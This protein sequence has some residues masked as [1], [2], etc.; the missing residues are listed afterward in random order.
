M[1]PARNERPAATLLQR[2]VA[3]LARREHS[4]VELALKLRR[5]V[6][7]GQDAAAD[8]ESVLDELQ[9]RGLLSETRYAEAIVR[10]RA[11]RY[12]NARLAQDL[13]S[14]GVDRETAQNA[15]AA[16]G[17]SEL[18]RAKAVWARRFDSLPKSLDE[19]ARQ[20]RYLQA[21]GFSADTI[22]AVLTGRLGAE[23]D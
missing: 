16:I 14:R 1:T 12:G 13:Q 22:R 6:P 4:R 15:L 17:T 21:R 2:A 20:A 3:L 8:I 9:R 10:T 19:R 5:Y 23:G 18:Q 7:E 11:S